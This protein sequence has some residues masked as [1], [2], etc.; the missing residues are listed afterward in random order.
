MNIKL[1]KSSLML[2]LSGLLFSCSN[3]YDS[4]DIVIAEDNLIFSA[5]LT[6]NLGGFDTINVVG[7]EKWHIDPN[8]Y[9][10]VSGFVAN[11]NKANEAWLISPEIDLTTA[12][13]AKLTFDHVARYFANLS[14]EATLWV[15]ENYVTGASPS[16]AAWTKLETEPFSDPGSWTFGS[17]GEISL[18]AFAGKKIRIAF[19]YISTTSKAGSWEVKNFLVQKGEAVVVVRN[20]GK[21]TETEPYTVAGAI[22]YQGGEKWVTGYIVGYVISG[23]Y[24][25]YVFGSDTCTQ[26]TNIMIADT[27]GPYLFRTMAIQLPVGAVRTGINLKDNKSLIG[28][29]VTLAGSLEAYFGAPGMRNTIYYA[30]ANGQT[31][32]TKPVKTIFSETFASSS[33][34]AFTIENVV[35]PADMNYVWTPTPTFGMVASAFVGGVNRVTES[36]LIS[37]EISLKDVNTVSLTFEHALN[38]LKGA[39]ATDYATVWI[40][41]TYSSGAPASAAWSQLN[42]PAYPPGTNW[43]FI[44]SGAVSLDDF[45]GEPKVRLAFKYVSTSA[46]APTWEIKNVIVK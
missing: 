33:Q 39:K 37:P 32:G 20:W 22:A 25:N 7:E 46:I 41:T 15:S 10:Y 4:H 5:P 1:N 14:T 36:W 23:S 11:S 40:S 30:L 43:T 31:G 2:L 28:Q 6:A 44:S 17:S 12:E 45:A 18:T 27:I 34:G 38:F 21:G 26:T 9:A 24:T 13:T 35:K 8:G 29:K 16:T 3:L 19:K 42:V